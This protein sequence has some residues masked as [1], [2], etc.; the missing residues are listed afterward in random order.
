MLFS[1]WEKN[2]PAFFPDRSG[3]TEPLRRPFSLTSLEDVLDEWKFQFL[4]KRI[5]SPKLESTIMMQYG[6]H[7]LHSTWTLS[8]KK[9][10]DFDQVSFGKLMRAAAQSLLPDFGFIHSITTAETERG[11]SSGSISF[12]DSSRKTKSLFVTTHI[13]RRYIPDIYWTTV[14]GRQY[15]QLFSRSRLLSSPVHRIEELD[16]GSV[17][18]QL[19]PKLTDIFADEL[20]F[21]SLRETVR[22]HLGANSFFDPDKGPRHVYQVPQFTW[23]PRLH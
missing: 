12:L 8:L 11:L 14:F 18:L 9:I 10:K 23:E 1:M 4:L 2:A 6:P 21:E 20:H 3:V 17:L 5:S 19:T 7:R 22:A 13:L 15:V 16:N